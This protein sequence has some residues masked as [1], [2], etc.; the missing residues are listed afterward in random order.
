MRAL[1]AR[2]PRATHRR[3]PPCRRLDGWATELMHLDG[4]KLLRHLSIADA[5]AG[6]SVYSL[7]SG[8]LLAH[9]KQVYAQ[10]GGAPAYDAIVD[11]LQRGAA[12]ALPGAA[13]MHPHK[14]TRS[15]E[16]RERP[17]TPPASAATGVPEG[18]GSRANAMVG[19]FGSHTWEVPR[20]E[21]VA[22]LSGGGGHVPAASGGAAPDGGGGLLPGDHI[23]VDGGGSAAA[24]PADEPPPAMP[25]SAMPPSA[26]PPTESPPPPVPPDRP[27][28]AARGTSDADPSAAARGASA[29]ATAVAAPPPRAAGMAGAI[30]AALEALNAKVSACGEAVGAGDV[31]RASAEAEAI[32][33]M[34]THAQKALQMLGGVGKGGGGGPSSAVAAAVR[35]IGGGGEGGADDGLPLGWG[36]RHA[37]EEE[38]VRAGVVAPPKPVPGAEGS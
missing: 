19:A 34:W 1:L 18:F 3:S 16:Q 10:A 20:P 21:G 32:T 7:V 26:I 28:P 5:P 35:P 13:G 33:A 6:Q 11:A 37:S 17:T 36:T 23:G 12:L 14:R 4:G 15:V 2:G 24:R 31:E 8:W 29:G 30:Q 25:P 9:A 27:P 38:L 22:E